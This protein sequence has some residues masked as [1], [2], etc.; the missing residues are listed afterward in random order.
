VKRRCEIGRRAVAIDMESM[1]PAE[2][3]SDMRCHIW[4]RETQNCKE[5]IMC[6][7]GGENGE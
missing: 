3:L 4:Q 5:R 2:T 1:V 6:P 7:T